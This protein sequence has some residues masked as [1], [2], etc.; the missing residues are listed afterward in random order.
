MTHVS[1]FRLYLFC[2][3]QF[4]NALNVSEILAFSDGEAAKKSTPKMSYKLIKKHLDYE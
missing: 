2:F 3:F 4:Y 1:F